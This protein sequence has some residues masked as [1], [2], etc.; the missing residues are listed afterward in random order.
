MFNRF[1]DFSAN[2]LNT[3]FSM[4]LAQVLYN[5]WFV[6]KASVTYVLAV[7]NFKSLLSQ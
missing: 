2:T 3:S 1:F 5:I 4:C 6:K 7:I